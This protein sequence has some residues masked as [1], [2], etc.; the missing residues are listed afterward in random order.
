MAP[1]S[2][3]AL[4]TRRPEMPARRSLNARHTKHNHAKGAVSDAFAVAGAGFEPATSGL[5]LHANAGLSRRRSRVE[6][7]RFRYGPSRKWSGRER[8]AGRQDK[9]GR[10]PG[11]CKVSLISRSTLVS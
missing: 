2:S 9:P 6:S 10:R 1:K 5:Y 8:R 3:R 11:Q 7:R 4:R